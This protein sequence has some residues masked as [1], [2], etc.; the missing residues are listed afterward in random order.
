MVSFLLV[1]KS[2]S[3]DPL[4]DVDFPFS[5]CCE[6]TPQNL[7]KCKKWKISGLNLRYISMTND[8]QVEATVLEDNC[9]GCNM[10]ALEQV[11]LSWRWWWLFYIFRFAP[12]KTWSWFT[13]PTT[14]MSGR[15]RS[16]SGS[17]TTCPRS[18]SAYGGLSQ[19]RF[20]D[21]QILLRD[22]MASYQDIMTFHFL[23]ILI[24]LRTSWLST[25]RISWF[26][27]GHH[28]FPLFV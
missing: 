5:V 24:F 20:N 3:T 4:L 22:I 11:S 8:F 14:L 16:S 18:S 21:F 2:Q 10:A 7:L 26:S 23:D 6:F 1:L 12:K 28:D 9:C 27:S 25:F 15:R 17:T 13:W 19:W